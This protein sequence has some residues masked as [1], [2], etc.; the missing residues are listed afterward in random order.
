V[1]DP[2]VQLEAIAQVEGDLLF[3]ELLGGFG[4][5]LLALPAVHALALS[6]HQVHV[7]T[8]D[9]GGELL[10][11]D[12]LVASY[13]TTADHSEGAPRAAVEAALAE[14][15]YA[16]AVTTTTYD[17]IGDLLAARVPETVTDLWR[18]PPP[19]ELVDRRFLR[20]LA[21]EGWIRPDLA[22]L[23]PRLDVAPAPG[24]V[25]DVLL[26]PDAGMP[27][28]RWPHWAALVA[29]L[30]AAG[31]DVAALPGPDPRPAQDTGARL[32][33]PVRLRGLA[34][35]A[36]AVGRAGGVVVGADTGPVRLAAAAGARTVGLFGPTLAARYGQ[37]PEQGHMGLQGLPGCDVRLPTAIT[38]QA[39][40]WSGTC[41]L[42]GG[43]PACMADIGVEAVVQA[44][45]A[46]VEPAFGPAVGAAPRNCGQRAP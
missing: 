38:E 15:R 30:R 13:R 11:G 24:P 32:L 33:P 22:G 2:R 14:R 46:T 16:R 19:D 8:F 39:C 9:P 25:P 37:R 29:R 12:P 41:P 23:P 40:W 17:G 21:A 7:L 1:T 28:K 10:A 27:V 44:F 43:D 35:L 5:L 6:G 31:L 18:R 42:T 34:A 36:A 20:L 26:L 45:E 3:V 4:D